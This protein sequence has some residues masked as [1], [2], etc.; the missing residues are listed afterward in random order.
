MRKRLG[1]FASLVLLLIM[2]LITDE[3]YGK[4]YRIKVNIYGLDSQYIY[5]I[6]YYGEQ[7]YKI[8]SL[9]TDHSGQG[10]FLFGSDR[11]SGMYRIQLNK[12]DGMDFLYTKTNVSLSI[13]KSFSIDSARFSESKVNMD[14]LTYMKSKKDFHERYDLLNPLLYYYPENDPF[15]A[16]IESK[17]TTLKNTFTTLIAGLLNTH[18]HDLLGTIIRYD[19]LKDIKPGDLKP[20]ER[21][22]LKSHYFDS[23]DLTDTLILYTPLL[24]VKVIDYLSLYIIPGASRDQQEA[25]F[26][27]AVD[28][29]MMFTRGD[30]RIRE[31]FINYMT[32]GFQAYGLEK[33]LTHLV[34]NYMNDSTCV[35]EQESSKMQKRIEGFK[36]LAIGNT[37]PDFETL[38]ING[39][40]VRLST[41]PAKY[42]VLLFWSSEC[43]HCAEALPALLKLY[44]RYRPEL[45]FVAVSAD[46][47][48][49]SWRKTVEIHSLDWTNIAQLKGWDGKIVQDYYVYATPTYL[50]LDKSDKILAKP[51]TVRELKNA[52]ANLPGLEEK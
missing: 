36:K 14:F 51:M 16:Q 38:D 12:K 49:Q 40:K 39:K 29:L 15:Y 18:S 13:D 37:A 30:Q 7:Q 32:N 46:T 48:E 23:V 10:V 28:T 43:P 42:K 22:Y 2:A 8:D 19:Q 9:I 1:L 47:D 52:I 33:V 21:D 27:D 24:P 4:D 31:M 6:S 11:N 3:S 35:S 41:I 20:S 5:L 34:E 44:H 25:S 45:E 26:I 50:L 17:V